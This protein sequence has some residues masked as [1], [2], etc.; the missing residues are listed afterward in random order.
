MSTASP[1]VPTTENP[2]AAQRKPLNAVAEVESQRAI[3]ETQGAIIVAQRFPRDPVASMDRILQAF[4][5]PKLAETALYSYAR[6][7]TDITGPSIRAAETIAQS[8]GNMQYGVREL[9]Q[10]HGESTVEA[11]CWDVETNTRSTKIFTVKHIRDTRKGRVFLEDQRD[12]Y[13]LIANQGARRLRACILQ[14]IPGDVVEAAITQAETTLRSK[15]VITAELIESTLAKFAE[16]GVPRRAVEARI[17]RRIEAVT[18]GLLVQL[19]KIYNSVKDGM[20]AASDWFDLA[21]APGEAS[22]TQAPV[23][24]VESVAAKVA[25]AAS[26][27]VDDN[28]TKS[29]EKSAVAEEATPIQLRALRKRVT[30]AWK[31]SPESELRELIKAEFGR[32]LLADCTAEQLEILLVR[33]MTLQAANGQEGA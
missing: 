28:A 23:S 18:P 6:G 29:V 15:I 1:I 11:F 12:I 16:I 2:F 7:G 3:T 31:G 20:S 22:E 30:D 10:R 33:A 13:E 9:E 25:Q 24:R 8:W 17:Q 26:T 14:I 4:T 19:G 32:S 5:R 21:P 27:T